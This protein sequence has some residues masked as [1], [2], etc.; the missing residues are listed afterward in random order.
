MTGSVTFTDEYKDRSVRRKAEY[1]DSNPHDLVLTIAKREGG[2]ITIPLLKNARSNIE[3]EDYQENTLLRI[4]PFAEIESALPVSTGYGAP[5]FQGK[6]VAM[7]RPG[8]LYIFRRDRLWRELEIGPDSKVSDVDMAA[9]RKAIESPESNLRI[10][11]PAEGEW[12]D[13]VLVPVFLQG[14]GVMHD[15][16]MAYS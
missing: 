12:L 10:E 9:A 15:I 5:V 13:D 2:Q 8:Y 1:D 16:R 14:Q 6:A 3:R 7:L 11:R 4:K